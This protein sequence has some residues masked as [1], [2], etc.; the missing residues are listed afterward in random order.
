LS[1]F[2]TNHWPRAEEI[3]MPLTTQPFAESREL[4]AVREDLN[5]N[6]PFNERVGSIAAGAALIGLAIWRRSWATLPLA[7]GGAALIHRGATGH[8]QL[9]QRL[10]INSRQL[11]T[12]SGVRGNKGMKLSEQITIAQPPEEVYSFWRQLENLAK[13]MEHVESVEELDDLRSRWV[14]KG[15]AGTDLEWTATILTDHPNELISWE[16]LPGAEVQNAGSVRF[17]SVDGGAATNLRVTLQYLPPAGMLGA[18]VAKIFGEA[19]DQQLRD[20]LQRLKELL[21]AKSTAGRARNGRAH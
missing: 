3:G 14:V 7:L 20:D 10:G 17:E 11:N 6:V 21:E 18:A 1:I 13:F 8:C 16:S 9:Y 12:E 2:T 19:P 15:P 4:E 5:I